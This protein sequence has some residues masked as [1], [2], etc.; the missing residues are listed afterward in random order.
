MPAISTEGLK[1]NTMK[2]PFGMRTRKCR[3]DDYKFVYGLNK[4]LLFPYVPKY[5]K[6]TKKEF[7]KNFH[8]R[9]KEIIILE[10]DDNKIGFYHISN[11]I[12]KK[13]ALYLS[14]IFISPKYQ[15]NGIGYFLMKY[16][17]TLG[18]GKIRLQ[19]W[20]KNPAFYFYKKLGYKVVSKNKGK[21]LMEKILTG[22]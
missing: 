14:S 9:Y 22:I 7:D 3:K 10:L 11:D 18:Y 17:E 8:K 19:V 5:A 21:Y 15:K 16:F 2:N 12:Y 4:K 6:M 13:N 1:I 20:R